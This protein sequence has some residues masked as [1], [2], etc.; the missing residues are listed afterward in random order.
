[1]NNKQLKKVMAGHKGNQTKKNN[2]A[3]EKGGGK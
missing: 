1:M 2:K 3:C